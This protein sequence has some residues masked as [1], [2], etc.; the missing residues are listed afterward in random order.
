MTGKGGIE[1]DNE[2]LCLVK[3]VPATRMKHAQLST[4]SSS[5]L[6]LTFYFHWKTKQNKTTQK[7]NEHNFIE[8]S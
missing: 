7:F 6:H 1:N 5:K 8:T 2:A 4:N 3:A